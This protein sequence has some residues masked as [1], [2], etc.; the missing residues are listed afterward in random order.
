MQ[1]IPQKELRNHIGEVLRRVESGQVFTVTV[2]S[3]AVAE[4]RPAPKRRWV[5]GRALADIWESPSPLT[6][7]VDLAGLGADLTDP[8][9]R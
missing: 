5:S 8:F 9:S 7:D 3:R 6:L 1:V 4:L 2:A